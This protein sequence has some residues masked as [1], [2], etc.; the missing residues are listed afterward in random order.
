KQAAEWLKDP[1]GNAMTLDSLA[2][3]D[4][5]FTPDRLAQSITTSHM[6]NV[7]GSFIQHTQNNRAKWFKGGKWTLPETILA[8]AVKATRNDARWLKDAWG[9]DMKVMKRD[10]KWENNPYGQNQFEFH[11]I[12]SAGPDGKFGTDDDVKLSTV[13]NTNAFVWWHEGGERFGAQLGQM[14]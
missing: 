7:V 2:K 4:K 1:F 11:E 3:L 12:V 14:R 13:W 9:R 10:K 6:Q 5:G 8:D